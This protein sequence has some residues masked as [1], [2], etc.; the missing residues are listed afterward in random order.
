MII[1]SLA[2]LVIIFIILKVKENQDNAIFQNTNKNLFDNVAFPYYEPFFKNT[3]LTY[4]EDLKISRLLGSDANS[5]RVAPVAYKFSPYYAIMYFKANC[6]HIGNIKE[7]NEKI[8]PKF[9][10]CA[11]FD[12]SNK[13]QQK[14][15]T[16]F[17]R[18]DFVRVKFEKESANGLLIGFAI[19]RDC[20]FDFD[21]V[22]MF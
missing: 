21:D 1:L 7:L 10:K 15:G 17:P 3:I 12:I 9:Q 8:S 11:E 2:L 13:Y 22:T 6:E 19:P 4:A 18:K 20:I 5:F 14:C 16:P